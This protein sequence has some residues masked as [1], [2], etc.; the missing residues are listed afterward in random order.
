MCCGVMKQKQVIK[1]NKI[2]FPFL[3]KR[4]K[5]RNLFLE[6][7]KTEEERSAG[8]AWP[9]AGHLRQGAQ[10]QDPFRRRERAT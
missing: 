9:S 6:E 5:L 1:Q 4:N 3:W 2:L 8:G 10:S 7:R